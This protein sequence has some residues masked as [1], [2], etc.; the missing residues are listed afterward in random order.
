MF[1]GNA[2]IESMKSRSALTRLCGAAAVLASMTL[3]AGIIGLAGG[4]GL[5]IRNWL[6]VLFQMNTGVGT[7]PA[8]PLN[9]VNP[10]DQIFLILSGFTFLG[11]W[12]GPARHQ[13]FWMT[14]AVA[15]PFVGLILLLFTH[16]A[17]RSAVMGSGV[18]V[19]VLMLR[20][21]ALRKLGYLGLLANVTLLIADFATSGS[22]QPIVAAVIAAGYI[23]MIAWYFLIGWRELR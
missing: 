20:N 10:L 1:W 14:V 16:E 3:V 19:A 13:K 21:D 6:V 4:T 22:R 15:L 9:V 7:L 8:D 11:L 2:L 5:G 18:V 23:P 17:G 12:P